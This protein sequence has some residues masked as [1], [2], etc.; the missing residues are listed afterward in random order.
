[1]IAAARRQWL[2]LRVALQYFTRLPV[3]DLGEFDPQWLTASARYFPLAGWLVGALSALV[4]FAASLWWPPAVAA[5]LA[6]LASILLTGAFHE[7]GLADTFDALGG[8]ADPHRA[9]LIMKDSR[10]GTYG[11]VAL[12][13][14]LGLRWAALAALPLPLACACLVALHPAARAGAASLMSTLDYLRDEDS[15]AK[16]VAQSLLRTDLG[17][18]LI[19]GLLPAAVVSTLWPALAM[20]LAAGLLAVVVIRIGCAR[21]FSRR[22]GGYTGDALGCTEQLGELAFLLAALAVAAA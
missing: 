12:F 14:V 20:P 3:G 4:L 8:L 13:A 2:L 11:S 1:M 17:V 9:L 7:D 22:L 15:K 19:A 18:A 5:G 10:I 6:L 21:W 16:P